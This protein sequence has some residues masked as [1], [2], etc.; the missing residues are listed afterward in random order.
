MRPRVAGGRRGTSAAIL[1][2]QARRSCNNRPFEQRGRARGRGAS[3]RVTCEVI[4]MA[5][6][7]FYGWKL[8]AVFWVIVFINLAFAA[9]GSPVMNAGMAQALHLSR[10]AA[11]L[12]YEVYT[13]MS[14]VPAVLVAV[15][16][17]SIGVRWTVVL[18]SALITAGAVAMATLVSS[19][20]GAVVAFGCLVGLG[21]CAGGPLGVQ[22]GV[23]VWFVRRRAL[24]LAIVY[25]AGGVGGLVAARVLNATITAAH[26]NWRMGWWLLAALSAF[27]AVIAALFIRERPADLGQAPDGIAEAAEGTQFVQAGDRG[28][29]GAA[30][31]PSF[32]T[33]EEWTFVEV[34]TSARFWVMSLALCGAG[35]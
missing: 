6:S 11:G 24:A 34:L 31:R 30:A 16:I 4:Q 9:Y 13:V 3:A 25:A 2:V 15:L 12:P 7:G 17:R 27:A 26:G 33:S 21:V 32:I 35:G 18:G 19:T 1:P 28:S 8:I 20:A 5:P 14:A 23:V 22:P 10:T 29:A